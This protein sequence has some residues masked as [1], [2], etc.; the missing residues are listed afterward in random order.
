MSGPLTPLALQLSP[1]NMKKY[2]QHCEDMD[3][4]ACDINPDEIK[5]VSSRGKNK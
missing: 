4:L 1:E 5:I 2:I 3:K